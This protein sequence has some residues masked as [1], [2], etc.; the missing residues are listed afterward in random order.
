MPGHKT[1]GIPTV[2]EHVVVG[3]RQQRRVLARVCEVT[4][5]T[6]RRIK[7]GGKIG[8]VGRKVREM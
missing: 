3:K 5:D 6:P 7:Q 1:Q 8:S 2:V 4:T